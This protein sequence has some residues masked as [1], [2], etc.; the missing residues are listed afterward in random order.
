MVSSNKW[1]AC[2]SHPI[3]ARTSEAGRDAISTSPS[4]TRPESGA[5]T[6]KAR[7]ANVDFPVPEGPSSATRAPWGMSRVRPSNT[8]GRSADHRN[9][10]PSNRKRVSVGAAA[11][12]A[13]SGTG[14]GVSAASSTR[15]AAAAAC[16]SKAPARGR[17]PIASNAAT[18]RT[19]ATMPPCDSAASNAAC[20]QRNAKAPASATRP[21]TVCWALR[22]AASRACTRA[23]MR[24]SA[25]KAR[26]SR[27]P[28]KASS[29]A[30]RRPL[31]V[32]VSAAPASRVARAANQGRTKPASR[33]KAPTVGP[34]PNV[35][36]GRSSSAPA[37]G[38]RIRM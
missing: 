29:A 9:P 26:T 4:S 5:T 20:P 38:T 6:F 18:A 34:L 30:I 21:A 12:T 27:K 11:A 8:G 1:V 3:R 24:P 7:A 35:T 23:N 32:R 19:T 16:P 14:T 33:N 25:A 28:V 15:R 22:S 10:T 36:I 17:P 31:A 2:D 13:G 37:S